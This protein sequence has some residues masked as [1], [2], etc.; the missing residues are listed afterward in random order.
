MKRVNLLTL[1]FAVLI[2]LTPSQAL[3]DIGGLTKCSESP[4]FNKRLTASVK[5]L[6]YPKPKDPKDKPIPTYDYAIFVLECCLEFN[7]YIQPICLP[8][9]PFR[10]HLIGKKVTTIGWGHTKDN[11]E[12][13][14]ILQ[15]ID[16]EVIGDKNCSDIIGHSTLIVYDPNYLM[17][18]G[19]PEHWDKDSCQMDSG[20]IL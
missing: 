4:A 20:G 17:C 11:G 5:K 1:L 10:P 12:S 9:R 6:W 15:S 19:D 7:D 18:S 2:A 13:T 16:I 3:A 8:S 14:P